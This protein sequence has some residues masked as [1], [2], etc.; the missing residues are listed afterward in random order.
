MTSQESNPVAYARGLLEVE[1]KTATA[2]RDRIADAAELLL[3]ALDEGG[4]VD[5]AAARL[6]RRLDSIK[7]HR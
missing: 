3:A 4:D 5:V 1:A 6:A 7:D 2:Q